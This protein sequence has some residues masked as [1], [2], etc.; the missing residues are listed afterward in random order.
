MLRR[1]VQ[2]LCAGIAVGL[3]FGERSRI[4]Q[5]AADGFVRLLQMAVL[6]YITVSIVGTI[7]ALSPDVLRTLGA[8]AAAVIVLLWTLALGVT[9]LMPLTFPPAQSGSFFSTT[10]LE[11][12]APFDLIDLYIPANPFFALANNIVPAVVLFSIVI[13]VALMGVPRKDVL[14]AGLDVASEALG[15]A[16]RFVVTLTPYGVFVIA[17]TTAGTLRLEQAER[18]EIYL[19]AYG[20]L[21]VLLSLWILPALVSALTAIP[22]REIL[23]SSRDAVLVAVVA[24]DLFI[25]L[26]MLVAGCRTLVGRHAPANVRAATIDVVVPVSYNFPHGGKL[27]SASFVLFA[28]WFSGAPVD[29]TDYGRLAA[30]AVLS[31]FGSINAAMPF[32]LDVF[33]VPADTFQ[34]FI[35]SGIVNARFGTLV[36]TMHTLAIALLAPYAVAG[37]L[38]WRPRELLRFAATTIVLSTSVVLAIRL[39]G[40]AVMPPRANGD[41]LA[42]MSIDQRGDWHVAEAPR[43][44][45]TTSSDG[46]RLDQILVRRQMRV[47]HLSDALPFVFLNGRHE[48]V[49]L[50]VALMHR[51]SLELGVSLELAPI[52]RE[53]LDTRDG[54]SLLLRSGACDVLIGGMA[55]TT[56]R[57]TSMLLSAPYLDETLAFVV[58]DRTR[59]E[60]QTW[61]RIRS[62]TP[63]TIAVPDVP[64]YVERLQ[65]LLPNA[66]LDPVPTIA[67][68]FARTGAD[69]YA[70][71]AERGSAWTLRYPQF[72]VVVPFPDPIKIPIAWGLPAAEP[73]LAA[74]VNTWLDL[75]RRDGTIEELYRYWILGRDPDTARPRWSIIRDVLHWVD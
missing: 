23:A 16:M 72:S 47:C 63:L 17:A 5:P 9:F 59:G 34:L 36:A 73:A 39:I 14:L 37:G 32:M 21:A 7:G 41:V 20:T 4:L 69:A 12:P 11:P 75:K 35:A 15:R 74:F 1:A 25:A 56:E 65:A 29:P 43:S 6:P 52:G 42:R 8:R 55:I 51:L 66:R 26:P 30:T 68:L 13:G 3:F 60:F 24:G 62:R 40:E 49:G 70:L 33:D 22:M 54:A 19:L 28:G 58:A 46:K 67:G 71:P 31:C 18:L 27:L 64:Y 45:E 38:R 61:A 44:T 50:D 57:S 2:A 10:L 53:R 48:L